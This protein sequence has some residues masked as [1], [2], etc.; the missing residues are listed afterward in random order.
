MHH[1]LQKI[2]DS[3]SQPNIKHPFGTHCPKILLESPQLQSETCWALLLPKSSKLKKMIFPPQR[4]GGG[5]FTYHFSS[6]PIYWTSLSLTLKLLGG[7]ASTGIEKNPTASQRFLNG[8]EYGGGAA[9]QAPARLL[10]PPHTVLG[11]LWVQK[12]L[13]FL[14]L[15]LGLENKIFKSK[16]KLVRNLKEARAIKCKVEQTHLYYLKK[17]FTLWTTLISLSKC[18]KK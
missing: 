2:H 3:T 16:A 17:N 5:V 12:H 1:Q 14:S 15:S 7:W 18:C 6:Y 13:S 10:F 8:G 9:L 11:L 4:R